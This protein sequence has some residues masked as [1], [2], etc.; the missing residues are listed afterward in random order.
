MQEQ[1]SKLLLIS[2]KKLEDIIE[3]IEDDELLKLAETR[4][5]AYG[6]WDEANKH[7]ISHKDF[8]D[9]LGVDENEDLSDVEEFEFE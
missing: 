4:I 6:G 8:W 1:I 2:D 9:K 3:K 5:N 7:F